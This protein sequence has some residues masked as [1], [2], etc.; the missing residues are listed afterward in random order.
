MGKMMGRSL[1]LNA[2]EKLGTSHRAWRFLVVVFLGS[3]LGLL[4]TCYDAELRG[5]L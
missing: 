5:M 3:A 1:A 2:G 4:V